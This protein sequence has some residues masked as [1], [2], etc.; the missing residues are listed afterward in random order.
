M[1]LRMCRF[2][3]NDK[4]AALRIGGLRLFWCPLNATV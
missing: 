1:H 2:A 3:G 4:L